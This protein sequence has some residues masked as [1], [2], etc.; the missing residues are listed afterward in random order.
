MRQDKKQQ[1]KQR[2]YKTRQDNRIHGNIRQY[3]ACNGNPIQYNPIQYNK[4]YDLIRQYTSTHYKI[5]LYET[6]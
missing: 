6:S 3:K 5:I 4:M 1:T 2:Q